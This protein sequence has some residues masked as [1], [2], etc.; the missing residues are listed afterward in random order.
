MAQRRFDVGDL[1]AAER[2]WSQALE[3][4]PRNARSQSGL[5]SVRSRREAVEQD[6]ARR[7]K[8]LVEH[9]Q[10]GLL[11]STQL[12]RALELLRASKQDSID[13]DEGTYRQWVL[14]LTDGQLTIASYHELMDQRDPARDD[15]EPVI[16]SGQP[17]A[18]PPPA[19]AAAP[20]V[21]ASIVAATTEPRDADA[22]PI[23]KRPTAAS[24]RPAEQTRS[25]YTQVAAMVMGVIALI[26]ALWLFLPSGPTGD[27]P[28]PTPEPPVEDPPT[29]LA[30]GQAFLEINGARDGVVTLASGLQ[31]E[32]I[33]QGDGAQPTASDSV[34]THY[35]GTLIDGS[36][37]DST[38]ARDQPA[39]FPLRSTID[40]WT[41]GLQLM[42]AGSKFKFFIPPHLAYGPQ[43]RG[44]IPGNATLIF[45]VEL[46]SVD[47]T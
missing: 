13:V 20:P 38:Y 45:V 30:A 19:D 4:D 26:A 35:E 21:E 6:L 31:Y 24:S 22:E 37:F 44:R 12:D 25:R 40:G 33:E 29:A 47:Q 36:V 8:V 34:T 10:D 17:P 15:P 1:D 41:E 7:R 5:A 43:G 11:T 2:L 9:R 39:T 46:I 28:G 16:S 3:L 27:G 14:D 23:D 18:Q 42:K 32:I